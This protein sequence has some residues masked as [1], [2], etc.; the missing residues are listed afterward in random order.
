MG[1]NLPDVYL[2][3]EGLQGESGDSTYSG[4][5]GW[6]TIKSFNF[7]FGLTDTGTGS[8][9]GSDDTGHPSAAEIK[10]CNGDPAKIQ[11]L[12]RQKA[13]ASKDNQAKKPKSDKMVSGPMTFESITFTKDSDI[14]SKTL[15][16]KC[17]GGPESQIDKVELVAC[18]YGGQLGDEKL[19]FLHMT[20]EN[21]HL[22][23][24]KLNLATDGM[25]SEDIAFDYEKVEMRCL[26]TSNTTGRKLS[27]E[28]DPAGWDLTA[29]KELDAPETNPE[30]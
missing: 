20:F 28:P 5:E 10:A 6:I 26:W 14:M 17:W 16:E 23:S 9:H 21:V 11:A 25:P 30:N 15:M 12:I 2:R 29:H 13:N 18:R 22:K 8:Q 1:E 7:G 27:E 24:C 4:D 19:P 3:F